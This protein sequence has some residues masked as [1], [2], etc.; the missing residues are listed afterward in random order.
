MPQIK[1]LRSTHLI[2]YD[3]AMK[4]MDNLLASVEAKENEGFL[5]LLEHPP[6]ITSGFRSKKDDLCIDNPL[7]IFNTS[8]GGEYTYHGPGQRVCYCILPLHFFRNDIRFFVRE[9]EEWVLAACKKIGAECYLEQGRVGIWVK[10]ELKSNV[11]KK[12]ASIGLKIKKGISFHGISLNV[13]P[14]LKHFEYFVSC[15]IRKAK[16]TSLWAEGF[17]L[18]MDQVDQILI[19]EFANRFGLEIERIED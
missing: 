7:P 4:R 16:A 1:V 14:N 2:T 19:S 10:H 11:L 15:G 5:W 17:E 6:L 3:D 12:I 13:N 18:S 8:R 9:L